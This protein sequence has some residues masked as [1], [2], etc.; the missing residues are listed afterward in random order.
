MLAELE[1][2]V[3]AMLV[4]QVHRQINTPQAAAAGLQ[5][6]ALLVWELL[7]A[8]AVMALHQPSAELP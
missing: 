4:A 1:L 3:K 7:R 8:Q 6:L 5:Q 2:A